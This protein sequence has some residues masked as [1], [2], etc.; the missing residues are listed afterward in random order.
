MRCLSLAASQ[1]LHCGASKFHW[2]VMLSAHAHKPTCNLQLAEFPAA[3][4]PTNQTRH[5]IHCTSILVLQK[6]MPRNMSSRQLSG[7][8]YQSTCVKEREAC[9]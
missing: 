4:L 8:A 5:N 7:D 2:P 3:E 6:T 9:T 1:Q